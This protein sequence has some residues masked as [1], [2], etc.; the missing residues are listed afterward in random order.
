MTPNLGQG[1]GVALEDA[2]VLARLLAAQPGL[3]EAVSALADCSSGS[4]TAVREAA[5]T[6]VQAAFRRYEALRLQRCLPLTVRSWAMGQLLQL[7]LPPVVFARDAF[8]QYLFSPAHF[9]EHAT[10]NCSSQS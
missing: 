1:G 6:A 4:S 10:Y 7:Q 5:H 8:V 9:L 3:V 2:V